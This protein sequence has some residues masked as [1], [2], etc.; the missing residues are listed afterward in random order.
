LKYFYWQPDG[1]TT[2][3]VI[4]VIV[5]IMN[6]ITVMKAIIFALIVILFSDFDAAT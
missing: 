5:V 2:H 3:I 6:I 4:G 1:A